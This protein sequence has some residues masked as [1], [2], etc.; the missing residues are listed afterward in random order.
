MTIDMLLHDTRLAGNP[1]AIAQNQWDIAPSTPIRHVV[2]WTGTV[3]RGNGKIKRLIVMAHGYEDTSHR[4]GYGVQLGAEGLTLKTV[5]FF[6]PLKGWVTSIILYS[7][8]VV[9]TAPGKR[10]LSGDGNLLVARLAVNTGA[11]VVASSETQYYTVG[12]KA[13]PLNFGSWEGDIYLYGPNG[14]RRLIDWG[15]EP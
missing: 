14:Q 2:G 1:P 8:A 12:N 7:C 6:T 3:A 10:M 11:Y 4:G 13:T 15:W 5:D 9:D